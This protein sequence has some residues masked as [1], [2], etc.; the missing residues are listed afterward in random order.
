MVC[1]SNLEGY[2]Q[3]GVHPSGSVPQ[4]CD[5][6]TAQY[7]ASSR[8]E[9]VGRVTLPVS[10]QSAEQPSELPMIGIVG[11]EKKWYSRNNRRLLWFEEAGVENCRSLHVD[12]SAF[13]H[14]RYKL[15]PGGQQVAERADAPAMGGN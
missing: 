10:Q 9:G 14:G 2:T 7:N 13:P 8:V 1:L 12:W 6:P 4:S 5:G 15:A 3:V 11:Y